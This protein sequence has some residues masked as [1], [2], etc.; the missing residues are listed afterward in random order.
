[1]E[2]F[3]TIYILGCLEDTDCLL[4][5]E[6]LLESNICKPKRCDPLSALPGGNITCPA[7]G[8]TNCRMDCRPGFVYVDD[9][10]TAA[11]SVEVACAIEDGLATFT[12]AAGGRP[13]KQC[14]PGKEKIYSLYA[15]RSIRL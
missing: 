11:E 4:N 3:C 1:M 15:S 6:C 2:Y 13:L 9:A 8:G 12:E 7:E 10:G 5:E 14:A